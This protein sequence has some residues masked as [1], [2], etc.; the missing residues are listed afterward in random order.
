M[1]ENKPGAALLIGTAAI[2]SAAPDG[3]TIGISTAT[4]MAAYH[5]YKKINYDP[6]KDL[7]PIYFYVKSPFVLVVDPKLPVKTVAS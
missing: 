7:T 4:P 3:H 5:M 2:A 6:E 1:I